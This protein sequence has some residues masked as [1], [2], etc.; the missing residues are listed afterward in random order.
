MRVSLC[1]WLRE[2]KQFLIG[3]SLLESL[4]QTHSEIARVRSLPQ[5]DMC[6]SLIRVRVFEFVSIVEN[7]RF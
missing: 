3:N 7:E 2:L 4:T 5:N 6:H 1:V